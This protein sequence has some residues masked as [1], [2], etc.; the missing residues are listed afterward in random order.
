M[1]KEALDVINITSGYGNAMIL[2][3][4]SLRIMSGESVSV[5]GKNGMGKSTLLKSI[6]NF[7][8]KANGCVK[9]FGFDITKTRPHNIARHG[10]AYAAQEQ[11][12]FTDLSVRNNLEIALKHPETFDQLFRPIT[13]L[14]PVFAKRLDQP[15]GTLSGGEQ[16]ML[17]VARCLMLRPSFI[18][19]DEITEGL[20]P[21]VIDNI[22]EA[23]KWERESH[24]TSML[25][26]EQNIRFALKVS[27]RFQI[28]SKGALVDSGSCDDDGA[29]AKI[30]KHLSV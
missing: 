3:N 16:K 5:L 23:L 13:H 4:L 21:M 14:F 25:I 20:Q 7:L 27:D 22:A 15:A 12:L 9:L 18:M 17:L 2:R 6:M 24:G 1:N 26:I 8:P 29:T 11:P 10:I 28:M 30:L 19:L